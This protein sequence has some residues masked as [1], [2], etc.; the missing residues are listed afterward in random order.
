[1]SWPRFTSRPRLLH[2]LQACAVCLAAMAFPPGTRA[3]ESVPP[4]L[5]VLTNIYQIWELPQA[6]RA[7]PHR[8]RTELTIYYFDHE[9]NNAWGACQGRPAYLPIGDCPT[10]LKAGQQVLL[11][12]VVLPLRERFLWDQTTVT[13]LKTN[14]AFDAPPLSDLQSN[15]LA[16]KGR[17]L[18]IEGFV[19]HLLEDN[20]HYTLRL[21]CGGTVA[22]AFLLK[23]TGGSNWSCKEGD[24]VR[25]KSV[26]SP[27]FDRDG[28]ISE[29]SLFIGRP[30]DVRTVGS[31]DTDPRFDLPVSEISS[32]QQESP[33]GTLIHVKGTVRSHDSGKWVTL[34][35]DSGQVMIQ[36]PQSQ[37]L[38]FGDHV[39]A[40]G[41]PYVLGVQP[42][43]R[44]GLYRAVPATASPSAATNNPAPGPLRLAEWV[45]DL[46][47][48]QSRKGFPVK[49]RGV[50]T[51]FHPERPFACVQDASG[52]IRVENPRWEGTDTPK[53]GAIVTVEGVTAEG[54]FVPVIT[55]AVLGRVGFY[56]LEP[57]HL[58]T[59]EQALTGVEDGRWVE[60]RGYVQD[61]RQN[62][63][64][65]ILDL[66][67][68]GGEFE[69]VLPATQSFDY[70][71]GSIIRLNGV[72]T[73]VSNARGQ[74]TGIQI[75]S[76][77]VKCL[78]VEEP[79]PADVFAVP[80]R[81][82]GDLR[83]YNMQ[84]A[85]NQRV[86]TS[87]TVLLVAPGRCV[88]IQDGADGLL[89]LTQDTLN[90]RPGDRIEVVGFAGNQGRKFLLREAVCR[91]MAAGSQPPPAELP[92]GHSVNPGLEGL[93]ARAEGVL[94]NAAERDGTV[95]LLV[96]TG[97]SA[98]E[99]ALESS[100][101]D[102]TRELK[103]LPIGSRLSLTGVYE[104]QSDETAH[105]R[106]FVLLLRS[107]NDVRVLAQPSWWTLGR[108]VTALVGV[109]G[110]SIVA[111][112]WGILISRKNHL[113]R[114]AQSELQAAH[115]KL[116]IRVEER[117]Q[118][119]R[120]QVA[121]KERARDELAEA[122]QRLIQ[123]SRQAGMAEVA[124]GVLHNVGNV[125][126]SVNVS[127][128]LLG[129]K[130]SGS[131][132][133]QNLPRV[134]GLL[135]ENRPHLADYLAHDHKGKHLVPYLESLVK[136]LATER[137]Q[138]TAEL[139]TLAK[140]IEH[141]KEIVSMQ[142]S[143]AQTSGV[144][145]ILQ[146]A[147]LLEEAIHLQSESFKRHGVRLE[148]DFAP[149]PP[150]NTDRHKTLQILTNLLQNAKY[151]CDDAG[152]GNSRITVRLHPLGT[153]RIKIEVVDNGV[154]IA[155]ENLTRIF[156]FGFTT[157]KN[158]HGFGLHSGALA[159]K[160]LGG[161]LNAHSAG[162]GKGA[163]FVLELPLNPDSKPG[164]KT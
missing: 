104:V 124:T 92:P 110:I 95:K 87:G 150:I 71:R 24:I 158:G 70:L 116:E 3:A 96:Q 51:W 33:A 84:N 148:R 145:E 108:L 102:S 36:S 138:V 64:L 19:D 45:R 32:I 113:L 4:S 47:R 67:T 25:I 97:E 78:Q 28:R 132:A 134:L 68:S 26:F 128:S 80:F 122:Q 135:N 129:E 31:L 49:L 98:F 143:Y 43:I 144:R 60:M 157:R 77:E 66:S 21:I 27:Q 30:E 120:E 79:A 6:E 123:A 54:D 160:E 53:P 142:Q 114:Q 18:S 106:R 40:V 7:L 62:R 11:D 159:A 126:N 35:D 57:G 16:N 89:A 83:R 15:P 23:N 93:L 55:N 56:N 121:A 48:E 63:G 131:N 13:V 105:P 115:D 29:L 163:A 111:L 133:L 153:D 73:A 17:L 109:L 137:S 52:G 2:T 154:G 9:W 42:C 99:A 76:P 136:H 14:L 38:R 8:M 34:W 85:L 59:L 151:A 100:P 46:S 1:M 90:L 103:N 69:A 130:F 50:V 91:R 5:P 140:N 86:R 161:S 65:T 37:A 58:V 118:E 81:P 152:S 22:N 82:L 12:G 41:Y 139:N 127:V 155:P 72:C 149:V 147:D 61:V 20:T 141:I 162:V 119:L 10:P 146:P 101:A 107:W 112:A 125:L 44:N 75:W 164:A 94:L 39:E 88:R 74:L 117:T 156:S